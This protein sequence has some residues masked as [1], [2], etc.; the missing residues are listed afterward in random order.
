[1][2][3]GVQDWNDT[4][5][6]WNE[7]GSNLYISAQIPASDVKSKMIFILGDGEKIGGYDNK[8][9]S[10]GQKYKIYSRGLTDVKSKVY[11]SH[12][13]NLIKQTTDTC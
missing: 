5:S 7:F 11:R 12:S 9:L 6:D 2:V 1:M 4:V 8:K 10:S 13:F 3:H